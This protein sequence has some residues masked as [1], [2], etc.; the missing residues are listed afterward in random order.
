MWTNYFKSAALLLGV[1][2]LATVLWAA[3]STSAAAG[4]SCCDLK[5]ACCGEGKA[6]CEA[7]AKPGCCDKGMGCCKTD[8][9]CC[10]S[11]P[12][13][14]LDGKACCDDAKAP[15]CGAKGEKK[16]AACCAPKAGSP[17]SEAQ[18]NG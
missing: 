13:C 18:P 10:N 6:C 4:K 12:A 15:C 8:A 5:L 14:C 3:E 7:K 11:T 2:A 1:S 16:T 9:A 17:T